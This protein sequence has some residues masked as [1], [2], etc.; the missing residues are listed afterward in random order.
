MVVSP[1]SSPSQVPLYFENSDKFDT[2][3]LFPGA[4]SVEVE[5]QLTPPLPGVEPPVYT[6]KLFIHT[7]DASGSGVPQ[8]SLNTGMSRHRRTTSLTSQDGSTV[9]DSSSEIHS[10]KSTTPSS[11]DT[12]R[13]SSASAPNLKVTSS[14]WIVDLSTGRIL[15]KLPSTIQASCS[16]AFGHSV[17]FGTITGRIFVLNYPNALLS[18]VETRAD[19]KRKMREW[20]DDHTSRHKPFFIRSQSSSVVG[21][22][23]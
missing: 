19:G 9:S 15:S 2:I 18:S 17:A 22:L 13:P 16:D 1:I 12:R 20:D 3:P 10:P 5:E 11:F 4:I 8:P 14:K 23:S 7:V 21:T 6:P